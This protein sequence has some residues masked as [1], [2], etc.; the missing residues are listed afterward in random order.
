MTC[1]RY[2]RKMR[3]LGLTLAAALV[4]GAQ[5]IISVAAGGGEAEIGDGGPATAVKLSTPS[6]IVLDPAGNI[7]FSDYGHH[8]IRKVTPGGIITTIAGTGKSG[9]SGDGGPATA[10]DIYYPKG[11]A[12]DAQGNLFF[13][14]FLNHRVRKIDTAGIITTVAGIGVT[15]FV[16]EGGLAVNATLSNPWDVDVDAEGNLYIADTG[17]HRIRKVNRLGLI[18][19]VAGSGFAGSAGDGG[20]ALSATLFSPLSVAVDSAGVLYI[21][22]SNRVRKAVQGGDI[23][24]FAGNGTTAFAGDGGPALA[25]SLQDPRGVTVTSTGVVYITDFFGARIRKVDEAGTIT[26]YAGGGRANSGGEPRGNG[27]PA[28]SAFLSQPTATALDGAGNLYIAEDFFIRKVAPAST[29]PSIDTGGIVNASGY[30]TFLAPGTIFTIFGKNLG[31]STIATAAA[32]NYPSELGG[33]TV[34]FTPTNGGAPI[35]VKLI[36]SVATQVA[37]LIPSSIQ[38]AAYAVRVTYNGQTSNA[39]NLTLLTRNFGI[40]TVNNAGTG[41]AQATIGNVNGGLSLVRSATGSTSFGG[42]NWVLTPAHP[43]DTLVLW[44]TGGGADLANDSGGSSGDQTSAGFQ[45]LVGGRLII[46]SYAGTSFG[47]PGLWQVNFTLPLDISTGCAVAVQVRSVAI[48]SNTATLAIA[49][50]GQ[51]SCN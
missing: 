13:A 16:G 28:T 23:R 7:Y 3:I 12:R 44:G 18:N 51:L 33:T 11:L 20:P 48:F 41:P 49:P 19:T 29:A 4:C 1:R 24:A 5:G 42:F 47:Y 14:D 46:P 50:P 21:A 2:S 27:G 37:G 38:Q 40:S 8:R 39:Q 17:N 32:P 43:G 22:E 15:G 9:F 30:Q 35:T 34:T 6:G 25:A 45:V 36:Y 31:P 26:T 10:A